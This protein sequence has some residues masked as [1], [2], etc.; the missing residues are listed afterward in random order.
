MMLH[1][2]TISQGASFA[3]TSLR[4]LRIQLQVEF[5]DNDTPFK[6]NRIKF[7]IANQQG[8]LEAPSM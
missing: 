3:P 4:L 1:D 7:R 2:T 8:K 5:E 6:M